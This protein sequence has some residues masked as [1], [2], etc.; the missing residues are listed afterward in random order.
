MGYRN[1]FSEVKWPGRDA[2]HSFTSTADVRVSG[3]TSIILILRLYVFMACYEEIFTFTVM[4]MLLF[5]SFV[6][7][8]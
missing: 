6:L 8:L 5:A 3:A 2:D 7:Q 1:A 4:Y